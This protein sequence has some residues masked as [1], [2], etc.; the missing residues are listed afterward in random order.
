MDLGLWTQTA[1]GP[2]PLGG[3]ALGAHPVCMRLTWIAAALALA[4]AVPS[5]AESASPAPQTAPSASA[6][7]SPVAKDQSNLLNEIEAWRSTQLP[8]VV[9]P[10]ALT[11]RFEPR[12]DEIKAQTRRA[13]T[14][15]DLAGA[16]KAF[17][18]W[19]KDLLG[20]KFEAAR[21]EGLTRGTLAQF[22]S[23]QAFQAEF[24]ASLR[25]AL[26]QQA[27]RRSILSTQRSASAGIRNSALF[28]DGTRSWRGS[29][30]GGPAPVLEPESTG[31]NDP[32]R[33]SKVRQ[34]LISQGASPR[35]VDLAIQEAIRQN[36]DPLLVLSVINQE[37]GF[38]TR[39]TSSCGARGLMQIMPDTGR[40]L[41]V[42]DAGMLYDAQT[43][44]RAGIRFL[45]SL[46]GEFADGVMNPF[47]SR[48]VT[49]AV[50]AYN[51]GPGAVEKYDG[52][53]PY[54]ETQGYVRN[55]I[56]YY[57]RLKQYL[58]A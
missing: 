43:N 52:V 46:C 14:A 22:S 13:S 16:R 19:K 35:V 3:R 7:A 53:P 31:A 25:S 21:T 51:A 38:N 28:F 26:A 41:G 47:S 34:I 40:G 58:L 29:L 18:A 33:Y 49:S 45:K 36:A 17:E 30:A 42:R 32:S 48:G 15:S 56:G 9:P 2:R 27:A 37:S 12:L 10:V 8:H 55:V 44:L 54:R 6:A 1:S 24:S 57:S 23:E 20:E 39:A 5:S 4:A 50:A 11:V